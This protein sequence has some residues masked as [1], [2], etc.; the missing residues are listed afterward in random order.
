VVTRHPEPGPVGFV[1]TATLSP[2][3]ATQSFVDGQEIPA[4]TEKPATSLG[5]HAGDAD[6]G[7][8]DQNMAPPESTATHNVVAGQ[9]TPASDRPAPTPRSVAVQRGVDIPGSAEVSTALPAAAAHNAGDG[10]ETADTP[11]LLPTPTGLY[12]QFVA[13]SRPLVE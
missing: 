13:V 7:S 12:V 1:V 3:V 11:G 5:C 2:P 9:E 4:P 10:Q 6:E 8:L